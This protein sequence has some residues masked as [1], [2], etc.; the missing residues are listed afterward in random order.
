MAG[1]KIGELTPLGRNLIASDELELSLA[2]SA[3]SR[4]IR[5]G[6]II[7]S[8]LSA[9]NYIF[10]NAKGTPSQNG[11][12]LVNAY[13]NA[14]SATPNGLPLSDDNR[15]T[16]LLAPGQYQLPS[17]LSLTAE[18]VDLVSI[19]G[20]KDVFIT[21]SSTPLLVLT[22]NIKLVGINVG[23]YDLTILYELV[24][25]I[26]ENCGNNL[27]TINRSVKVE[28]RE[29]FYSWS[30]TSGE[31]YPLAATNG[32]V[33]YLNVDSS[34]YGNSNKYMWFN[35]GGSVRLK[36]SILNS[37][38]GGDLSFLNEDQVGQTITNG[39]ATYD[40]LVGSLNIGDILEF[41]G[42]SGTFTAEA[43]YD[44]GTIIFFSFISGVFYGDETSL[45]NLT[46]ASTAN[47]TSIGYPLIISNNQIA[48][49]NINSDSFSMNSSLA[50]S[51]AA[52]GISSVIFKSEP[53]FK[54]F[55]I[56]TGNGVESFFNDSSVTNNLGGTATIG[57]NPYNNTLFFSTISGTWVG[58]TTI[59][60]DISLNTR[61]ITKFSDTWELN[62]A[63]E[64]NLGTSQYT[65]TLK[66]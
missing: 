11:S 26:V 3:G 13:N 56:Y 35:I 61:N 46:N 36:D 43:L 55:V 64:L 20:Q 18:Y 45:L 15:Y 10:V 52:P 30:V 7:N 47:V 24:N 50:Q 16:I 38:I 17:P 51:A 44:T 34:T 62:I 32:F 2:G 23:T 63:T 54:A 22:D 37:S 31:P 19:T 5:G 57:L 25:V 60:G 12:N 58:A 49:T 1:K 65:N 66:L 40:T 41:T 8:V 21:A 9:E 33:T 53:T 39:F 27:Y 59:T 6:E 28:R 14:I 4:K 42:P 29:Y 48:S